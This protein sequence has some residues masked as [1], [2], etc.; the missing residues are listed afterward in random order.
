MLPRQMYL[1]SKMSEPDGGGYAECIEL[2]C[3]FWTKF[4]HDLPF[5]G[6]SKWCLCHSRVGSQTSRDH[7]LYVSPSQSTVY[8]PRA[9]CGDWFG[10]WNLVR[11]FDMKDA[12]AWWPISTLLVAVIYTG[13]K[14]LVSGW[15][16]I[17]IYRAE[18]FGSQQFLSIPVYTYVWL[19]KM[20]PSPQVWFLGQDLQES[21]DHID[22]LWRGHD[23]QWNRYRPHSLRFCSHGETSLWMCSAIRLTSEEGWLVNHRCM[24]RY[25]ESFPQSAY[26]RPNYWAWT[27]DCGQI[28]DWRD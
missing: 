8:T 16:N 22:S 11:D 3:C 6:Y 26:T 18:S 23:V 4:H 9:L 20:E 21:Y 14:S 17:K 15:W 10:I 13:S 27:R 12:K 5:V 28:Y 19:L 2:V 25:L 7:Q 24:G 1:R